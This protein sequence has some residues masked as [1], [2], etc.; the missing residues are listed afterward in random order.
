[1]KRVTYTKI[2]LLFYNYNV[3]I[4]GN[5]RSQPNKYYRRPSNDNYV[6]SGFQRSP[7]QNQR[8]D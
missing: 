6:N 2:Y 8:Y 5:S 4:G 7:S 3:I 1:M